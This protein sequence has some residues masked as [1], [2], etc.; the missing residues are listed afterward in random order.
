MVEFLR[1]KIVFVVVEDLVSREY[2]KL[3]CLFQSQSHPTL[4]E[5]GNVGKKNVESKFIETCIS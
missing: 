1:E 3:R 5:I 2:E 4:I